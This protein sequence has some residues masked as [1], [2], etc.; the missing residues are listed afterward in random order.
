MVVF[1][2]RAQLAFACHH[3][4]REGRRIHI[5]VLWHV[6][7]VV[8]HGIVSPFHSSQ[9]QSVRFYQPLMAHLFL[10]TH[11][12]VIIVHIGATILQ[13]FHLHLPVQAVEAL[14]GMPVHMSVI[15]QKIQC[16]MLTESRA[17]FQVKL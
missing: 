2:L 16:N 13:A 11:H 9:F 12:A 10:A 6:Q 4:V 17:V 7:P 5:T 14:H 1:C 3:T 8:V 15:F